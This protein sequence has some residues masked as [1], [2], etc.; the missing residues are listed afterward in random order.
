[1]TDMHCHV[2]WGVDDGASSR[3]ESESLLKT[4]YED[5]VSVIC[6]TPHFMPSHFGMNQD[7]VLQ[8][9]S[10]LKEYVKE[11]IP[12]LR[13]ALGN[14]LRY[15]PISMR[16]LE[17]G[18]CRTLNGTRYVLVDFSAEES[19]DVIERALFSLMNAGYWPVLA[20]AERYG[21]LK[22]MEDR[23]RRLRAEQVVL[24]VDA[25]SF[26]GEWGFGAKKRS[27]MLLKRELI[28]LVA[29][30][31]HDLKERCPKLS[32]IYRLVEKEKGSQFADRV[33]RVNP[34]RILCGKEVN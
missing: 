31:T 19:G 11:K 15:D 4:M 2:I 14:E 18:M 16:A 21:R 6:L 1:M 30:D 9:F 26:S 28:D 5:G 34:L 8:R 29:S 22:P 17:S 7:R 24:Q 10:E 3:E 27:R 32:E 12:G 25:E 33:L 20:H 13:L 23:I